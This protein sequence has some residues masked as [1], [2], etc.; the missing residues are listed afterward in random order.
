[1]DWNDGNWSAEKDEREREETASL[2]SIPRDQMSKL[3]LFLFTLTSLYP[4][5]TLRVQFDQIYTTFLISP[6]LITFDKGQ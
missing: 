2:I 5:S 1:M 4:K 3:L 6:I